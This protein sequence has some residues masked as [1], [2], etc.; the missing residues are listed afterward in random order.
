[1]E[2]YLE[3]CQIDPDPVSFSFNC[4]IGS[5]SSIFFVQAR[6]EYQLIQHP[7]QKLFRQES[8]EQGAVSGD[9][10]IRSGSVPRSFQPDP[11][12]GI[13]QHIS[14]IMHFCRQESMEL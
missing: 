11:N 1:M 8:M 4:P 3:A 12:P 7:D 13:N 10:P 6:S 5:G 14:E 9:L 2:L